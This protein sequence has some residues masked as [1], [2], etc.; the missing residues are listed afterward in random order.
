MK[1]STVVRALAWGVGVTLAMTC[2]CVYVETSS[3]ST[4]DEWG[5][6]P[7]QMA[8][9]ADERGFALETRG[10]SEYERTVVYPPYF[11]FFRRDGEMLLELLV[12]LPTLPFEW[13]G[14]W[15]SKSQYRITLIDRAATNAVRVIEMPY[16][17]GREIGHIR[18][19]SH[20]DALRHPDFVRYRP[21][22]ADE[23]DFDKGE[24][25]RAEYEDYR[26]NLTKRKW[27]RDEAVRIRT[28][29]EAYDEQLARHVPVLRWIDAAEAENLLTLSPTNA[30]RHYRDFRLVREIPVRLKDG[31]FFFTADGKAVYALD[32]FTARRSSFDG[33][34]TSERRGPV[35]RRIDLATGDVLPL[36]EFVGDEIRGEGPV[37]GVELR[38]EE[39]DLHDRFAWNR[40]K[41]GKEAL[42]GLA[43]GQGAD[44][45][46][47]EGGQTVF[48]T[49]LSLAALLTDCD[50]K[51]TRTY[52]QQIA[53]GARALAG[54]C[55]ERGERGEKGE[56]V[57]G[58]ERDLEMRFAVRV[59]A[60]A[61]RLTKDE[62][63][64]PLVTPLVRAAGERVMREPVD[65]LCLAEDLRTLKCGAELK[66]CEFPS[67][68][69]A[70]ELEARVRA[71]PASQDLPSRRFVLGM[72]GA[73]DWRPRT[74]GG[75]EFVCWRNFPWGDM[76]RMLSV[77]HDMT[78]LR[79]AERADG[80]FDDCFCAWDRQHDAQVFLALALDERGRRRSQSQIALLT[81]IG[82]PPRDMAL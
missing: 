4:W 42:A 70:K 28:A 73:K 23:V 81:L 80:K 56:G 72:L 64:L 58:V 45:L 12:R 9:D 30:V 6:C 75:S 26:A 52:V 57:E 7:Q 39:C 69:A 68:A 35:M 62:S 71:L 33:F 11:G 20:A 54:A 15:E 46:W 10:K 76:R 36:G 18:T 25:A 16:T 37:N 5:V 63:L 22:F 1:K 27:P 43:K 21:L 50:E 17:S 53:K 29:K 41:F 61:A 65:L 3:S 48:P 74:N 8:W 47:E 40:S 82:Y 60:E 51:G 59:L 13:L 24:R 55:G 44:G 38:V 67:G 77:L 31:A 79:A 66:I 2:G 14:G 49:A 32:H 78:C 34:T 19:G